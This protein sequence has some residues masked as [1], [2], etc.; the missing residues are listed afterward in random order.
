MKK[1]FRIKNGNSMLG[2]VCAGL[3]E[4]LDVDVTIIRVLFVLAIIAPIPAII[5]Y[6]IM[7]ILMPVKADAPRLEYSETKF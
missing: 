3:A 2:G 1:L 4:Y 6:I 5:P 7:W